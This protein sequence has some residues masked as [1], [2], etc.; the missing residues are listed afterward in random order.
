MGDQKNKG[1]NMIQTT[2][3]FHFSERRPN[4]CHQPVSY[5]HHFGF[6]NK[7]DQYGNSDQTDHTSFLSCQFEYFSAIKLGLIRNGARDSLG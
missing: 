4:L 3:D 1:G 6:F 7:L 2:E 5:L